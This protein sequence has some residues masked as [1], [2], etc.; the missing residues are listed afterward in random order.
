AHRRRRRGRG[1]DGRATGGRAVIAADYTRYELV[2]TFRNVRFFVFSVG[3]PLVLYFLI[4]GPNKDVD[5]LGDSG[6][7]APLYF[8]VG[9]A[10]FGTMTAVL[11]SGARIAAERQVG[12]NRQL[13]VTPLS[14][15]AYFRAK[16]ATGYAMAL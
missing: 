6:I 4:A 10:A 1:G 9:L 11:A 14:T 13:R 5:D 7:S 15:R 3:F 16:V 2:R 8:M 12:W